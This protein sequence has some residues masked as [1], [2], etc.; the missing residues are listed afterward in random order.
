MMQAVAQIRGD[1]EEQGG[2]AADKAVVAQ[3]ATPAIAKELQAMMPVAA[4]EPARLLAVDGGARHLVLDVGARGAAGDARQLDALRRRAAAARAADERRAQDRHGGGGADG[5]AGAQEDAE[6]DGVAAAELGGGDSIRLGV[7]L[8][9]GVAIRAAAAMSILSAP[10]VGG[11]GGGGAASERIELP[12]IACCSSCPDI[13]DEMA[14]TAV[15][16]EEPRGLARRHGHHSLELLC[17]RR[18]RELRNHSL[19]GR[20]A[21]LLLRIAADLR[22]GLHHKG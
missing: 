9:A 10:F 17:D 4:C 22:D 2:Y 6:P 7:F 11:A 1:P 13:E 3:L 14:R 21:A 20:V 5:D 8:S 19:V 16:S 15:D 12:S 18:R